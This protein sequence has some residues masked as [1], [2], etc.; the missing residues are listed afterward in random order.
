MDFTEHKVNQCSTS[1]SKKFK[2]CDLWGV[3]SDVINI[4][5]A[6][7]YQ[8]DREFSNKAEDT[9]PPGDKDLYCYWIFSV[10]IGTF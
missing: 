5:H 6:I 2:A 10:N 9:T 7:L 4:I 3:Y 1:V 8:K